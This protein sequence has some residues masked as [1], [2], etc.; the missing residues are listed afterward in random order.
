M[1]GG[2]PRMQR[3]YETI[4]RKGNE[5]DASKVDEQGRQIYLVT[6]SSYGWETAKGQLESQDL[7]YSWNADVLVKTMYQFAQ[8][9]NFRR[10]LKPKNNILCP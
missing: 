5:F 3:S 1:L 8:N 2:T 7:N 10:G 4:E 9:Y 6:S